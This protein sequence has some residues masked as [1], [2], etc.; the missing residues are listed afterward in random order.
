MSVAKMQTRTLLQRHVYTGWAERESVIDVLNMVSIRGLRR[1]SQTGVP[2][3]GLS[4]IIGA[5]NRN[6]SIDCAVKVE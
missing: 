6:P 5:F 4:D 1:P 3:T 2:H